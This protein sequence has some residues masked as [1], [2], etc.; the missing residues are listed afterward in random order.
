MDR[1]DAMR[2]FARVLERRSFSDASDDL[3]LPRSTVTDAVKQIERRLGARLL[4][5]TT[6]QV[7]PTVDGEAF[8]QRCLSIISDVEDAENAF[9]G[10]KPKG[11][12][13]VDVHG[14]LARHFLVPKLPAF[15]ESYPDIELYLGEGDRL[16]DLV[17]EGIDCVLRVG[18]PKADNLV[19]KQI[20]TLEEVTVAA[21]DYIRKFSLP[22]H[23]DD[24]GSHQAIGFRVTG[25]STPLPLEF[26]VGDKVVN[27]EIGISLV[28]NSAEML[29]STSLL[30][31]GLIQ[32]PR[33]HVAR[34]LAEG[35]LVSVL[36]DFP[37][38]PTPVWLLYPGNR[39]YSPRVKVFIEW[40][41][42]AF[43]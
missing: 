18:N 19:A 43:D 23:P 33:Y 8:Y 36:E 22:S 41:A 31:L 32:V 25:N 7:T 40:L 34:Y 24:L 2:V 11:P 9:S 26:T 39:K 6:R 27:R 1:I 15:L 20:A 5:R 42:K 17:R 13:K 12:L 16:V 3:N 30:G 14:T 38:L 29:V 10:A 37:P 4:E 21:P 35:S 28:V